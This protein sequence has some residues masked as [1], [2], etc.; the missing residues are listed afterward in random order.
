MYPIISETVSTTDLTVS[1]MR[2]RQGN[3]LVRCQTAVVEVDFT[4][5]RALP[6]SARNH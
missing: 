5:P 2:L 1:Q 6:V 3:T 4:L